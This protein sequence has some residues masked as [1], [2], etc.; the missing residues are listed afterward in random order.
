M[1]L[2]YRDRAEAGRLLADELQ[3]YA[4]RSDLLILALPRGGVPVAY[5]V[6]EALGA[7]LD[8]LLVRKLGLP[9]HKELAMGAIAFGGVRV[10]NEELVRRMHISAEAIDAVAEE[11][12][13]ELRRREKVYRG[14]RPAPELRDR[15]VIVIDDGLATGATMRA[16]ISALDAQKPARIIVAVP[17]APP[18]TVAELR[19][20]V[21]DIVCPATPESFMSVGQWYEEFPQ[22]DDAKVRE[23]LQKA[24]KP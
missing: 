23:L 11:E 8:L 12:A 14:E 1:R 3:R 4:G 13:R 6:A 22:T 21:D 5:E 7:P 16:A 10:L 20:E 19:A 2:P 24:W 9:R 17:V 18:S 15:C